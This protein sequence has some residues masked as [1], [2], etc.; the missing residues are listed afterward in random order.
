MDDTPKLPALELGD[1]SIRVAGITGHGASR[2][3]LVVSSPAEELSG[4]ATRE[5]LVDFALA[6][7][8]LSEQMIEEG[9][10]GTSDTIRAGSVH[11]SSR[12]RDGLKRFYRIRD[13]LPILQLAQSVLEKADD[14][15]AN[16][17]LALL[18]QAEATGAL[19]IKVEIDFSAS[20]EPEKPMSQSRDPSDSTH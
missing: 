20:Q 11:V 13:R 19:P 7:L 1:L 5:A 8:Q 16:T 9:A 4:L 17:L 3:S 6:L 15:T 18:A 14:G 10:Y 12:H 2:A